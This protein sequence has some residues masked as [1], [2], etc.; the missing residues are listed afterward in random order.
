MSILTASAI[1]LA[2]GSGKRMQTQLPK[3]F[4]LLGSKPI[5]FHSFDLLQALPEIHEIV[6][7]CAPDYQKLFLEIPF[8]KSVRFAH[9]GKRRQDSVYNGLLATSPDY[10]LICIHDAARPLIDKILVYRVLEAASQVGAATAAM[11]LKFTVKEST[12]QNYVKATLDRTHLWE[13]QTPQVVNREILLEGFRQAEIHK[14]TV[15]DDVSL[16]ELI[17]REVKLVEGS[18]VNLKITTPEDLAIATNFLQ[19]MKQ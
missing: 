18:H 4:L 16:A 11:P 17:G 6:V 19:A 3:Q 13:I 2:G 10:S 7:V 14:L 8:T 1:L 5:V 15:T 9:P 12:N